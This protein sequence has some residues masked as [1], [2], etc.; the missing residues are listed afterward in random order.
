MFTT[1]F[2]VEAEYVIKAIVSFRKQCKF[3]LMEYFIQLLKRLLFRLTKLDHRT[4]YPPCFHVWCLTYWL[5]VSHL[6]TPMVTCAFWTNRKAKNEVPLD[7][8]KFT[9][10]LQQEFIYF[11]PKIDIILKADCSFVLLFIWSVLP[12]ELENNK[13]AG[14]W[15]LK[16]CSCRLWFVVT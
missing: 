10:T 11:A 4:D 7:Q 3:C 14:L 9:R 12:I 16:V 13:S 6:V 2:F 15:K 1:R 8:F 5:T